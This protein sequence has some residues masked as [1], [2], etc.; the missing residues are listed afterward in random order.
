MKRNG[1]ASKGSL[2]FVS[3]KNGLITS[4]RLCFFVILIY[5][6]H[7]L[8]AEQVGYFERYVAYRCVS[9]CIFVIV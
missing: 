5:I 2:S 1:T 3:P 7:T 4:V 6:S 8:S 9:F